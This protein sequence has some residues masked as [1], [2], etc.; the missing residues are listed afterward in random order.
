MNL[1]PNHQ[2]L[3]N[4]VDRLGALIDEV[5]LVG[6]CAAGLLVTDPGSSPVR[7]TEDVDLIV[8]A[9]TYVEYDR[10]GRR[11]ASLGFTQRMGAEDPICRWRCGAMVLD[12]MPLDEK[13]LGFSNRWYESG[14]RTRQTSLL[15]GGGRI[16]HLD[17]PHFLATKLSA[18]GSR[19][20]SDPVMSHDLEDL[21]RVV[22]GRP[23]IELE[24]RESAEELVHFVSDRIRVV[25]T[26]RYFL[27]ALPGYL[28]DVDVGRAPAL[29]DRL[30]RISRLG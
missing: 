2:R 11:L 3:E 23:S 25:L 16:H 21:V 13:I 19:G 15:V 1:D 20:D 8:E 30:E 9:T 22:D 6:G 27:E 29:I 10:Y 18:Y 12:L 26:D 24:L 17:A 5:C 7:A 28:D 14:F 4:I